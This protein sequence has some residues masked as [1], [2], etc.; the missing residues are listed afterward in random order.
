MTITDSLY[1][2]AAT[3]AAGMLPLL[4]RGE[5]K[6]ASAA[7][8]MSA[9]LSAM[10]TWAG[11]HRDPSRPRAIEVRHPDDSRTAAP[12]AMGEEHLAE[13][14]LVEHRVPQTRG[15]PGRA[16]QLIRFRMRT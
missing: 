6:L 14:R 1:G 11:Q 4:G 13:G 10:E 7:R 9:S 2:A 8:G 12:L 15:W 16:R 3:A 5:G